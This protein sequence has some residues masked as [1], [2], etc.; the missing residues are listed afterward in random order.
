[1]MTNQATPVTVHTFVP[2]LVLCL[3]KPTAHVCTPKM[4]EDAECFLCLFPQRVPGPVID[5]LS[6]PSPCLFIRHI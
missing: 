3:L 6:L 4:A 1:M 2:A 5:L